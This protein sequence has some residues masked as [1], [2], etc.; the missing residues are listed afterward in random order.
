METMMKRLLAIGLLL[1][2]GCTNEEGERCNPNR[3]T[4]DCKDGLTCVF[5]STPSCNASEPGSNCCGVSF[6]CAVDN[7]G[8]IIDTN[9]RCQ[10]DPDSVM[11][12][13][14]DLSPAP[15]DAGTD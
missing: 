4:N 6:C 14:L 13:M 8:N 2:V 9:P 11:A 5:P 1:F 7:A 15:M 12:C 3:A 10:P